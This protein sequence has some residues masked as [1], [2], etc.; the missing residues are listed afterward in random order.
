MCVLLQCVAA[1]VISRKDHLVFD[2]EPINKAD[3]KRAA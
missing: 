1:S 3:A 2:F